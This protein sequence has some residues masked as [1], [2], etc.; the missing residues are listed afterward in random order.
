MRNHYV[1]IAFLYVWV[2]LYSNYHSLNWIFI[3][4]QSGVGKIVISVK[5]SFVKI[6]TQFEEEFLTATI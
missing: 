1:E 4:K 6:T 2:I 3:L 5:K